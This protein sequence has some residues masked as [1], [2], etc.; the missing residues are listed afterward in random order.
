VILFRECLNE[1]GW[2]K[3]IESE[4]IKLEE[5]PTLKQDMETK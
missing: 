4:G 2:L 1:I 5:N 3:K